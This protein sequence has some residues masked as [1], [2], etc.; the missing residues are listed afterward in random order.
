MVYENEITSV[1]VIT[2]CVEITTLLQLTSLNNKNIHIKIQ[3]SEEN[4][5]FTY[6]KAVTV[7]VPA[8]VQ[9]AVGLEQEKATGSVEVVGSDA[10]YVQTFS[11]SQQ[12]LFSGQRATV[13]SG[14][15]SEVKGGHVQC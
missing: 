11:F 2:H 6:T 4:C 14:L 5:T 1:S 3:T 13:G 10:R 8:A 12:L 7:A 15:G 9:T